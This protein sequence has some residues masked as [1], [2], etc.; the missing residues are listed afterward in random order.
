LDVQIFYP[1]VD[2]KF[3]PSSIDVLLMERT[4]NTSVP[5]MVG[6]VPGEVDFTLG[7]LL[8]PGYHAGRKEN[9]CSLLGTGGCDPLRV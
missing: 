5:V 7:R 4:F 3:L 6:G 8:I 9:F 1:T 2:K